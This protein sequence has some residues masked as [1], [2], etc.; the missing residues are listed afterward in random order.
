MNADQIRD[1]GLSWPFVP[2][3]ED[4]YVGIEIAPN[5]VVYVVLAGSYRVLLEEY[6]IVTN[7]YAVLHQAAQEQVAA[8]V[9]LV[10]QL[11]HR[12]G[13]DD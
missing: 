4:P 8:A 12:G 2:V 7:Q 11:R 3:D 6:R 5:E 9:K 13:G 10:E 1:L